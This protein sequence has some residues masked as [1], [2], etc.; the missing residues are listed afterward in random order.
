MI[1]EKNLRTADF[2]WSTRQNDDDMVRDTEAESSYPGIKQA[3][4]ENFKVGK[5]ARLS[6]V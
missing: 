2:M 1:K 3:E 4:E 6:S 5:L